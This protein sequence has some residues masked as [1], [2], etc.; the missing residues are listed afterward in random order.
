MV[1]LSQK[2]Q[3]DVARTVGVSLLQGVILIVPDGSEFLVDTDVDSIRRR[4]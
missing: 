2:F 3:V 1:F 4:T